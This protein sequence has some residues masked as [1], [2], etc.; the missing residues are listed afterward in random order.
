MNTYIPFCGIDA[1][2][3]YSYINLFFCCFM[4]F[5]FLLAYL[6]PQKNE[7]CKYVRHPT[8]YCLVISWH[9]TASLITSCYA[10]DKTKLVYFGHSTHNL[11]NYID[12]YLY[13]ITVHQ[14]ITQI[15]HERRLFSAQAASELRNEHTHPSLMTFL[16]ELVWELRRWRQL[17]HSPHIYLYKRLYNYVRCE[18]GLHSVQIRHL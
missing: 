1:L 14:S 6:T 4:S 15:C 11:W 2:V 10:C 7:K 9:K 12:I 8:G 17:P 16:G 18:L 5:T 3:T 13:P